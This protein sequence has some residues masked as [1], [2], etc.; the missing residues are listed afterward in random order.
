M[1]S[2]QPHISHEQNKKLL[3]EPSTIIIASLLGENISLGL[4]RESICTR[5]ADKSYM[6]ENESVA[7]I[8]HCQK[9]SRHGQQAEEE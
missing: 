9:R 5:Q 1:F 2:A 8:D 6:L 7:Q 4:R 3:W